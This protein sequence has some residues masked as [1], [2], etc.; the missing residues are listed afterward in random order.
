MAFQ[1]FNPYTNQLEAEFEEHSESYIESVLERTENS[2]SHWSGESFAFRSKLFQNLATYLKEEKER[3]TRLMTLEMGKTFNEG[4]AEIEKCAWVCEYYAQNAES[5]LKD[6]LLQTDEGKAF[7]SYE[8]LGCVLAVMPWNFPFWQV[9]RYAAPTLMVG[10]TGILKHASNVPQCAQAIERAF[11]ESGFPIGV[12]QNLLVSSDKVEGI[13]NDKRIKAVT[14]TGSELAGSKVAEAAG[15]NI[16]T[17]VLELGGSDPF[18]VLSDA[19][20]EKTAR[21]AAKARMINCGQSCI[22]AKR[23]IVV[24]RV[25]DEFLKKFEAHMK[26]YVPGDPSLRTTNCGPMASK[27]FVKELSE[28]VDDSVKQGARVVLGGKPI[29]SEAAFFEPTI[30]ANV[31]KGM[32]A[33]EE[34]LFGPV[35]TLIKVKNAEEAIEVANDSRFGLGGSVWTQNKT[36]GLE[37]A[38]KVETGAMFVNQMVASDPRLPFGGIKSSGYGRELSHLGIKEFVNRKTIFIA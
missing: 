35:A 14:L 11:I 26:T 12:F 36:T 27:R 2:F 33:Y 1:S 4:V 16:K 37:V 30:L 29:D 15:R 32:R 8:P 9:F 5:F 21:I 24:E 19:D 34:E 13:I 20:L 7:I 10:N 18:I 3:L 17:S 23:F 31:E 6:E 25:Y 28:Q 38:R 22:A